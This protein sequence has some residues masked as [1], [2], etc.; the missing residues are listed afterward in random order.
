MGVA[1]RNHGILRMEFFID[2]LIR[3]RDSHYL[4]NAFADFDVG[5]QK[6]GLVAY[7]TY[8]SNLGTL[9]QM[10]CESLGFNQVCYLFHRFIRSIGFHND[11]HNSVLLM[12]IYKY[13]DCMD[14]SMYSSE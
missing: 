7:H 12:Q 3:F 5:V 6:L 8:N 10:G 2:Q 4:V 13:A 1:N 9:G 11:N 14:H